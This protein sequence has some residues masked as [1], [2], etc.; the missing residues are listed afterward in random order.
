MKGIITKKHKNKKKESKKLY[1]KDF[2][3]KER[4]IISTSKQTKL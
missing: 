3:I 2:Q 1:L 4:E